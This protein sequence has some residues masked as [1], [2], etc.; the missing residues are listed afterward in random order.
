MVEELREAL[1]EYRDTVESYR[2]PDNPEILESFLAG[3]RGQI[4]E[5]RGIAVEFPH[6]LALALHGQV[7]F[8][9]NHPRITWMENLKEINWTDL[10][11]FLE[12]TEEG[13]EVYEAFEEDSGILETAVKIIFLLKE[14]G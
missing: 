11:P 13:R 5:N 3:L 1:E 6:Y 7:R 2:D 9:E 4:K 8:S 10:R 14:E 12:V